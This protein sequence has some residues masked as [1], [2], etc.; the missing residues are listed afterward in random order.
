MTKEKLIKLVDR[1]E[2]SL[3]DRGGRKTTPP[4]YYVS[5]RH[6]LGFYF[7]TFITNNIWY[8]SYAF[9]ASPLKT[10]GTLSNTVDEENSINAIIFFERFLELFLKDIL[11]K[12]DRRFT[13]DIK[14]LDQN[15]NNA[16]QII[17][18]I[19]GDSL[20]IKRH[21]NKPLTTPF[22]QAIRRYY[23]LIDLYNA[24][25]KDRI[26]KKYGTI[27]KEY[28][29][30]DS[31]KFR[32]TMELL[33][34]YRDR[35]LHNGNRCPTLLLLD[36]IISQRVI[37]LICAICKKEEPK[38]GEALF[39]F[40][41]PTGIDILESICA[42]KFEF[43]DLQKRE[44]K[45]NL[46]YLGHLK[47]MGRSNLTMNLFIRNN[48]QA[49]HEY[50]YKDPKGRARRFAL[51]ECAGSDYKHPDFPAPVSCPCC[52]ESTLVV[53][54]FTQEKSFLHGGRDAD[55]DWIKCYLCD[56]HLRYNAGDP[57]YFRLSSQP[58]FT[59]QRY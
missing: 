24:G 59:S 39:Y 20:E 52:G 12:V 7:N 37:P 50:N 15:R 57:V 14:R 53:Y 9:D 31:E 47:E 17:T 38:L 23:E 49:G 4:Y 43:K 25:N 36:Y 29:F 11:K 34:W 28:S 19:R 58:L 2:V 33:S 5:L 40:K 3:F 22:R 56:Y 16:L 21:N 10:R 48:W 35:L 6:A 8:D 42:I 51:A 45:L 30:L 44:T 27:H 26:V 13:Y 32:A 1:N 46:L 54:R 18:K 55:I 41:T